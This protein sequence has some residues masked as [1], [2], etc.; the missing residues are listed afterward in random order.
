MDVKRTT[1]SLYPEDRERITRLAQSLMYGNRQPASAV[2]RVALEVL[3]IVVT[4]NNGQLPEDIRRAL[5]GK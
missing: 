4:R 3:E 2:L 1:I 5:E